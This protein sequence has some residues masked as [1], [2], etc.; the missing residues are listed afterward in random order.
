[1]CGVHGYDIAILALISIEIDQEILNCVSPLRDFKVKLGKQNLIW[2]GLKWIFKEIDFR[3][4]GSKINR[5]GQL[6]TTYKN[7]AIC[8]SRFSRNG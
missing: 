4:I 5:I 7:E 1:M 6:F 3:K 2:N 8:I